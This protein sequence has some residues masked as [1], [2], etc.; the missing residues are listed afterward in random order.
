MSNG[1]KNIQALQRDLGRTTAIRARARR[2][3]SLW[4]RYYADRKGNSMST[5]E[6]TQKCIREQASAPDSDGVM[7]SGVVRREGIGYRRSQT[8]RSER[9]VERQV[10]TRAEARETRRWVA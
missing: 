9:L 6:Y 5:M 3:T 4:F 2:I 8:G 7:G 10:G 1:E